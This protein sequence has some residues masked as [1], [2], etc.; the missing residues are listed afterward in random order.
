MKRISIWIVLGIMLLGMCGLLLAQDATQPAPQQDPFWK[1]VLLGAIGGLIAAL[2]G[3]AKNRDT[4][5]NTQEPI[6]WKYLG[7]TI[8]IGVL[9]GAIA[10]AL[11]KSIPEFF[12][13]YESLP[14]W[15][16]AMMGVEALLKVVLRQSI[17]VAMFVGLVKTGSENPPPPKPPPP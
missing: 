14:V 16:F 8:A 5:T 9:I 7:I 6:S 1:R 10:G 17:G 12:S 4:K 13:K 15:G 3:W 11:G 2:I